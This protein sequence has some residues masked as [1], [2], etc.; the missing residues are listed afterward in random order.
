MTQFTILIGGKFQNLLPSVPK[1]T[2]YINGGYHR[3]STIELVKKSNEDYRAEVIRSIPYGD[4]KF[5]PFYYLK[6]IKSLISETL[7]YE[8]VYIIT[9]S[10]YKGLGYEIIKEIC[11]YIHSYPCNAILFDN[12]DVSN[13]ISD[14][15]FATAELSEAAEKDLRCKHISELFERSMNKFTIVSFGA[16]K[17][18][19]TCPFQERPAN[20]NRILSGSFCYLCTVDAEPAD[21]PTYISTC[22]PLFI[23][24]K[25]INFIHHVDFEKRQLAICGQTTEFNCLLV[26]TSTKPTQLPN[27]MENDATLRLSAV[28]S[29]E[30]CKSQSFSDWKEAIDSMTGEICGLPKYVISKPLI[31]VGGHP[32]RVRKHFQ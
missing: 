9:N 2:Y 20:F 24:F 17:F 26:L 31:G 23:N 15:Q 19:G 25:S 21:N 18:F 3:Y 32:L 27:E 30:V 29:A 12:I 11:E 5:N 8:K 22:D 7:E 6:A 10:F 4:M 1:N 14:V 28:S 13:Y 16:V